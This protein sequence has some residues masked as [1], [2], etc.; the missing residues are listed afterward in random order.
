MAVYQFIGKG[1]YTKFLMVKDNKAVISV[2]KL[3]RLGDKSPWFMDP[4]VDEIMAVCGSFTHRDYQGFNIGYELYKAAI[5]TYGAIASDFDQT[6]FSRNLWKKLAKEYPVKILSGDTG[7]YSRKPVTKTNRAYDYMQSVLVAY[8]KGTFEESR[9]DEVEAFKG[10]YELRRGTFNVTVDSPGMEKVKNFTKN[11]TDD[12]TI[13]LRT[14]KENSRYKLFMFKNDKEPVSVLFLT[15][16]F[17]RGY[18]EVD[19]LRDAVVVYGSYTK[20][21]FRKIGIGYELYKTA[22][23]LF[24]IIVSDDSQTKDSR[25]I[26]KRL[27]RDYSIRLINPYG[28]KEFSK[29]Y[30]TTKGAY[31]DNNTLMVINKRPEGV[32]EAYTK[33]NTRIKR[34]LDDPVKGHTDH[35]I[36]I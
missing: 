11:F 1:R 2:L 10:R 23:D 33:G 22:I 26:W 25:A 19:A 32:T 4:E 20:P 28:R 21:E 34:F 27:A 5:E 24:D 36:L 29:P 8:K 3:R 13:Y 35:R 12:L 30:T 7:R 6:T 16:F 31:D 18:P 15:K 9:I 14:E 17:N